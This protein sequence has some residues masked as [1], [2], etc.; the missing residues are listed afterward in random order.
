MDHIRF[1]VRFDQQGE[2]QSIIRIINHGAGAID[3][4][5]PNRSSWSPAKNQAEIIEL[6]A[7][8]SSEI[9]KIS[10]D[11]MYQWIEKIKR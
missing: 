4:W 3:Y 7:D 5:D 11:D 10:L 6:I 9:Q 1:W 8:R 2:A